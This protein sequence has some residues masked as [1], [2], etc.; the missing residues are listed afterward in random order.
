MFKPAIAITVNMLSAAA[1]SATVKRVVVTPSI[2]PFIPVFEY[3][4]GNLNKEV[5][6]GMR[7]SSQT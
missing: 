7:A 5:V 1:K 2:T 4:T 6:S 3:V